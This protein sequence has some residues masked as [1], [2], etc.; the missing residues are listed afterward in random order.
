MGVESLGTMVIMIVASSTMGKYAYGQ[1]HVLMIMYKN[2][3]GKRAYIL[4]L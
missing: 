2:Y 3:T 4:T 1:L